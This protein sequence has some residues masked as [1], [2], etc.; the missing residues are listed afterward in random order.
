M[1]SF[2]ETSYS[3]QFKSVSFSIYNIIKKCKVLNIRYTGYNLKCTVFNLQLQCTV[4]KKQYTVY[5]LKVYS[6]QN[7]IYSIKCT[8]YKIHYTVYNL[9]VQF[10]IYNI[11]TV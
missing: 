11:C 9:D 8:V 2:Q 7:T 6:F 3:V 5:S 1:Y 10:S 4:A